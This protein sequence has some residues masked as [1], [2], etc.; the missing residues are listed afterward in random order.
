[1]MGRASVG[2]VDLCRG[3]PELF[4]TTDPALASAA[5]ELCDRCP[6]RKSCG[7]WTRRQRRDTVSTHGY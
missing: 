4:D 5:I 2:V 6:D 1:M 3:R 7:E